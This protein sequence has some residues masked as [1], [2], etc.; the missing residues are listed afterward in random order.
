MKRLV[1]LLA[2]WALL[3]PLV[4]VK[5]GG[6]GV[7]APPIHY[8]PLAAAHSG[9]GGTGHAPASDSGIGGTGRSDEAGSGIGGTGRSA[10]TGSGIGGT[11]QIAGADGIGG[12]GRSDDA[13]SEGGIGGTGIVGTI[14]GFAS[15]CV[16]GLEVH[17]DDAVPVSENGQPANARGLAVGQVVVVEAGMSQRGLEARRIA[18]LHA[19]EGPVTRP[20]DQN[21][22]LEV[23]GAPVSLGRG[24]GLEQARQLKAGDWVQVSG[25]PVQDA[26]VVASRIARIEPRAEASA[27]GRADAGR[28]QVGGVAVD[29]T[30]NGDLTVRGTWDGQR[31]QVR[32]SKPEAGSSWT[33]RPGRVVIE[34]RVRQRDG[35]TIRTGRDD[36][37]Q[38]LASRSDKS[39]DDRLSAGTL[40]RVTARLGDDGKL[41]PI[42]I[43]RASREQRGE[44]SSG[45]DDQ[46]KGAR[47]GRSDDD[48]S[49]D[50]RR[51]KDAKDAAR[52][53]AKDAAKEAKEAAKAIERQEKKTERALR[54]ELEAVERTERGGR[55]ERND[56]T[57]RNDRSGRDR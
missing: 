10:E 33:S 1:P 7:C 29:R 20:V 50:D 18:V 2:A 12:T 30:T 15:I 38:A 44:S 35:D 32:D 22:R 37:D 49:A 43:E 3:L 13:G 5:A 8:E 40:L 6:A 47:S 54:N 4:P 41:R 39:G 25:H 17:Y 9:I 52:D 48:E 31:L 42:R 34:T 53:A 16:N 26:G 45:G 57:D 27:S 14:T 46:G 19:L 28:L 55:V 51:G 36:V 11:G 56:R 23:M 24:V 21:G